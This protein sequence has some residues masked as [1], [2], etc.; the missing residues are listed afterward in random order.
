MIKAGPVLLQKARARSASRFVQSFFEYSSA[1]VTA[2]VG[3]PPQKPMINAAAR[4]PFTEKKNGIIFLNS[5]QKISE[6]RN[7]VK[8]F[9]RTKN[10]K[11][12]GITVLPQRSNADFADA[13]AF[14]GNKRR[15]E[16]DTKIKI[17]SVM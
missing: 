1:T 12:E 2:P 4:F 11:S 14:S 9:E 13:V 8:S 5:L 3:Y 16:S 7:D 6:R 10:G 17:E 15:P